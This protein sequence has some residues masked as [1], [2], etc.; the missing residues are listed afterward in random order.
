MVDWEHLQSHPNATPGQC[1]IHRTSDVFYDAG[2]TEFP[3]AQYRKVEERLVKL[4]CE[5]RLTDAD[6]IAYAPGQIDP[7]GFEATQAAS[8]GTGLS[9]VGVYGE[10]PKEDLRGKGEVLPSGVI[11]PYMGTRRPP[12]IDS[13]VWAKLLNTKVRC[14][15]VNAYECYLKGVKDTRAEGSVPPDTVEPTAP[16]AKAAAASPSTKKFA[17]NLVTGKDL[18]TKRTSINTSDYRPIVFSLEGSLRYPAKGEAG[19]A[20]E[21]TRF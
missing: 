8:D 14:E 18:L 12:G 4:P 17:Y 20:V 3:L 2:K 9:W 5:R 7:P 6:P 16:A 11:R 10:G 15:L 13:D 1:R 19:W 21:I